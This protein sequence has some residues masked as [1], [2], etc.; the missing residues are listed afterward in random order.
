MFFYIYANNYK[1]EMI[2]KYQMTNYH[3]IESGLYNI[4]VD[5]ILALGNRWISKTSRI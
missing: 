2:I 4:Y 5:I 1:Q 3:I